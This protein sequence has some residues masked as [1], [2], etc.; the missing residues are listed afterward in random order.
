MWAQGGHGAGAAGACELIPAP[1]S[2]R[3]RA[4]DDAR[5]FVAAW[6]RPAQRAHVLT[7]RPYVRTE[8]P[9]GPVRVSP[10][11]L[12]TMRD[13]VFP[14]SCPCICSFEASVFS[15]VLLHPHSVRDACELSTCTTAPCT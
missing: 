13:G 8:L 11:R 9:V 15:P 1:V 2:A 14:S 12:H 7:T 10:P 4:P 3:P 5:R 6:L